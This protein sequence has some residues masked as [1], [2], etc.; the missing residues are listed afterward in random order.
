ML[1]L[2]NRW[3]LVSCLALLSLSWAPP[4]RPQSSEGR[5]AGVVKDGS[6]GVLPGA[7][8]TVTNQATRA[9]RVATTATDGSF[10]LSLPAG[11]Y[12][13]VTSLKGFTHQIQNTVRVDAGATATT[14][15]ALLAGR[16][17]VVTV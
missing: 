11:V 5:L 2:R 14:D 1:S 3:L 9:V 6:G 10:S 4:A 12:S 7:T 13:V 8:V 17:E 16:E 15:F